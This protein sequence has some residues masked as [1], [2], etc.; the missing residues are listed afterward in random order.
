MIVFS[1]VHFNGRSLPKNFTK[2]N[3]F[4]DTFKNKFKLIALSETWIN[5]EK[6]IDLHINGYDLYVTNRANRT[7]GG[8]A[9]YINSNLKCTPME[10]LTTVIDDLMECVAVETE[11]ERRNM[12]VACVYRKP[13]SNIETFKD[14]LD[15]LMKDLNVNKSLILCGDF[16][17]DLLKVSTHKQTSDFLDTLYNRGL[18]PLIT[19]PSRVTWFSA[20]LID[21]IFT[22]V[23]EN[24]INSGLVRNDI[25]DHLPVFAT[26]NY[27]LPQKNTEKCRRYKKVRTDDRINAFRNDL[28]KQEW[29]GVYTD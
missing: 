27:E 3:E 7:G 15:E 1:L 4:L 19:K 24:S 14:S 6:D 13:G 16:N 23:L 12:I 28:L 25:S 20:T 10:C 8:V 2:I 11:L 5:E 21:N 18:Y 26:F 17:I 29:N 9:L 22:N